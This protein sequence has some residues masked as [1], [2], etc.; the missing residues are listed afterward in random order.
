MEPR[1]DALREA[2]ARWRD[3]PKRSDCVGSDLQDGG[4]SAA[5]RRRAAASI[6]STPPPPDRPAAARRLG[7]KVGVGNIAELGL[8]PLGLRRARLGE[9]REKQERDRRH[10]ERDER[11]EAEPADHDP[12]ERLARL[13]PGAAHEDQRHAAGDRRDHRHHHRPQADAAGLADGVL[14]A[15]AALAEL[16][17]ELHDQ[18]AV[19]RHDADQHHQADL[20]VD[21]DRAAGEHDREDRRREPERHGEHDDDGADE[22]FELRREHQEHDDQR[23]AEGDG[24]AARR[25]VQR[26]RLAEIAD[27]H[28][29]TEMRRPR[30]SR[31]VHRLAKIDARLRA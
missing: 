28:V 30:R 17:G 27:A 19:L 7:Q 2:G 10:E 1:S 9:A 6:A 21:V 14:D 5:A 11:R 26:R 8:E 16:V 31:G 20:A 23:E 3:P 22:T 25:L 29:G 12:A 24:N 4:Y 18:D 15:K 13:R